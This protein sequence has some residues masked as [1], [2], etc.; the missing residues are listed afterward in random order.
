M[1]FVLFSA[2]ATSPRTAFLHPGAERLF[3]PLLRKGDTFY[4]SCPDNTHSN[5]PPYEGGDDWRSSFSGRKT[6][7]GR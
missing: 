3:F 6:I 2:S 4:D 7:G 5:S 1:L